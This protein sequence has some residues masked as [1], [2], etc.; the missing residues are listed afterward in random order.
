MQTSMG[1]PMEHSTCP[2]LPQPLL[3]IGYFDI[4]IESQH[5]NLLP[6]HMVPSFPQYQV[7]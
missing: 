3:L 2:V 6:S 7:E 4:K 1:C 5:T